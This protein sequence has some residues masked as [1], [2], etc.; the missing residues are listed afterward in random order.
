M[1][2]TLINTYIQRINGLSQMSYYLFKNISNKNIVYL[3]FI[4][5]FYLYLLTKFCMHVNPPLH[6]N[7]SKAFFFF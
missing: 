6:K 5:C 2:I 3:F 7:K 1:P 4:V